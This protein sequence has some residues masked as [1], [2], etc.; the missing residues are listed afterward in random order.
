[1]ATLVLLKN[2]LTPQTREH[3]Q[4]AAGTP[5]IDWL[6]EHH[7][8]GFG[9]P[10]RFYVNNQEM[11]V[12][13]L[14]YAVKDEDVA[15]IALMPAEPATLTA[16]AVSLLISAI[17]SVTT[18]FVMQAFM[19]KESTKN[20]KSTSVY[21]VSSDQ[22]AAKLG[23][24]IP[25]VY[26]SVLMTPD[27]IS[28]PYV[29]YDW[30]QGSFNSQKYNGVQ[31][32]DLLLCCGQ[33]NV[34]IANIYL[35]D[36]DAS[37]PDADVIT[38]QAFTPAQH[39][40]TMGS[41]ASAMASV[42]PGFHENIVTSPEVSNQEFSKT[43]DAA[44]YFATCKPG[45]KGRYFQ[46]DIIFPG[47]QTNPTDGGNI[48]GRTTQFDVYWQELDD[49]DTAV[50][51][52]SSIRVTASSQAATSASSPT[53]STFTTAGSE[54]DEKNRSCISAPIR[55]SYR[56]DAGS[57]K[58]WAVKIV[59]YTNEP[60]GTDG[61]NGT[62]RFIWTG[63]KLFADYPTT[64]VYGDVTLLAV[65]V[66]AS[67]GIGSDASIRIRVRAN[68]RLPPP[69][70][71]TE[72]AT[73]SGAYAFADIYKNTTYGAARPT[74]ELDTATL[75]AL[76]T[77]WGSYQFNHVFRERITVWEALR[78][79]TIPFAAEPLPIGASM[80]VAQDGVNN[81]RS[82]LFTDANIVS[83]TINV[84]YSFDEEGAS[85]GVE[86]EY[87]SAKDGKQLYSLYP[88]TALRPDRYTIAG[89]TVTAH[90]DQLARL[91]WQR[92]R[93]QRKR[94]TFDTE[95]EGLILQLG[96]RIG[97]SHN[98]MKWG[99]GG[100]IIA[101]NGLNITADHA[102]DWSAGGEKVVL[103]KT[104]GG[105]TDPISVARGIDDRVM[106]LASSPG[107]TINVDNNYEY[108]SFAFGTVTNLVRDFIVTATKPT[109][110]NVVTVEA[111][112]YEPNIFNSTMTFLV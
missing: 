15:V 63:L 25:V 3:H 84:G 101:V 42:A 24:P 56:I 29:F 5:V 54:N 33:G 11:A 90:A 47:G 22:N 109:G 58:R 21:D 81:I 106:V 10:I 13:D 78:T 100:S 92:S 27:Y 79:V 28:Q 65:R 72:V 64:P 93:G 49:N 38:W 66:K 44:G 77:K 59:R 19:P 8:A 43:N 110:G 36:T 18:Y 35:A 52:P 83:N 67:Q 80:S 89:I 48:K 103:R 41:I 26:G 4:L 16:I 46:I 31:Y 6:Q 30:A 50:G 55:R 60:N 39:A 75:N 23:D 40:S 97:V 51:S 88:S 94:I 2:P 57:S 9:M 99:D 85:D 37:T 102:L 14:D 104:D 95:L 17:L 45:Q 98:V 73:T 86:V 61:P 91:I 105:V 32:L 71:G 108:T 96:D 69:A 34:D 87:L 76:H 70:G 53:M 107:I 82:A 1:M 12:D 20:S 111:A 68:R 7:P 112:N 62:D 74:S